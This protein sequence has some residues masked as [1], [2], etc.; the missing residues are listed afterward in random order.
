MTITAVTAVTAENNWHAASE[1][2]VTE[3]L[4]SECTCGKAGEHL[5]MRH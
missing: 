5:G 2:A 3:Q 4:M 1:L